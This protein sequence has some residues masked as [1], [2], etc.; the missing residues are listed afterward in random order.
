VQLAERTVELTFDSALIVPPGGEVFAYLEL[1]L[2]ESL[3]TLDP[4]VFTPSGDVSSDVLTVTTNAVYGVVREVSRADEAFVI[5]AF[6]DAELTE[7][8]GLL[9]VRLK[10]DAL[11]V[12]EGG[13][14]FPSPASFLGS[15]RPGLTVLELE[16]EL[17]AGRR[18]IAGRVAIV[19]QA[20]GDGRPMPVRIEG[21]VVDV[22]DRSFALMVR[23]ILSGEDQA[24]PVLEGLE[25]PRVIAVAFDDATRFIAPE[26]VDAGPDSLQLGR[27]VVVEFREFVTEPFP[28]GTVLFRQ[29]TRCFAGTL[30]AA[31]PPLVVTLELRSDDPST[32]DGAMGDGR[33]VQVRLRDARLFLLLRGRPALRPEDL[34]VGMRAHVCGQLTETTPNPEIAAREVRLH[35]GLFDRGDVVAHDRTRSTFETSQSRVIRTFGDGV[36]SGPL[37]VRIRDSARVSGAAHSV[38]GFFDLLD[39]IGDD[40]QVA[41]KVKGIGSTVPGQVQA[42]DV[43]IRVLPDGQD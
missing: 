34:I 33:E 22:G 17:E 28:A 41:V 9:R 12:D 7:P 6:A 4:P 43:Q 24:R 29:T 13:D 14:V 39:R 31:D 2:L 11:L 21:M 35:P 36:E 15:L 20:L 10:E 23:R 37:L 5:Q 3:P 25:D 32:R 42:F 27:I 16:G 30:V 18:L 26:P 38:S 19:D 8:L 40:R 1:D